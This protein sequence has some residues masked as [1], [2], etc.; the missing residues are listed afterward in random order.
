[1]QLN[2]SSVLPLVWSN[3]FPSMPLLIVLVTLVVSFMRALLCRLGGPLAGVQLLQLVV[4]DKR[5]Q[6]LVNL[7]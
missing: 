7:M 6:Q 1:M 4:D 3:N 5:T 2:Q